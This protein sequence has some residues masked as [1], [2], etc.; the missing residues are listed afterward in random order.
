MHIHADT[1][2]ILVLEETLIILE[3]C[4]QGDK[5]LVLDSVI[6]SN[7]MQTLKN[8]F[9]PEFDFDYSET[10]SYFYAALNGI[11]KYYIGPDAVY[12]LP[13]SV[14]FTDSLQHLTQISRLSINYRSYKQTIID[15]LLALSAIWDL[16]QTMD[17][18][19]L[20]LQT[21]SLMRTEINDL[22][23]YQPGGNQH[24]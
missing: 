10:G 18:R 14:K 11:N 23:Y 8:Y 1:N 15:H 19:M 17:M 3:E 6:V 5:S 7:H 2:P 13:L 16:Q 22:N 20:I 9:S 21:L 24:G 12:Q 4:L